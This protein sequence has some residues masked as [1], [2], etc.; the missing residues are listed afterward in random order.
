MLLR[1]GQSDLYYQQKQTRH[2][3]EEQ[4]MQQPD[5]IS[6]NQQAPPTAANA[7][8]TRRRS[9]LALEIGVPGGIL[10]LALLLR[11][12]HLSALT[13]SYDEG[14]YLASLRAMHEGYSLFTPV[15][16]SQP[17]FFLLSLS[18][19]I[20][21]FG[22]TFL[23]ARGGVV[24]FSLIGVLAMY[25]LG[26]R[27][28]GL[29]VGAAAAL[30]L[31]CDYLFLIQSQT[32]EAE[33]PSVALMIV[34]V[35]AA[36]YIGRYPWQAA[37][38]SG[39]ATALATLE[40]LFAGTV[41][42]PIA[43]LFLGHL[44]TYAQTQQGTSASSQPGAWRFKSRLE[45]L[46]R[47][48]VRLRG[49]GRYIRLSLA[50][51]G[52][53]AGAY[54]AGLVLTTTL[55]FLPYLGQLQAVYQQ[56][57]GFHLAAGESFAS[58]LS[59]NLRLVLLNTTATYPLMLLTLLGFIVGL[60]RRRWHV[61]TA[62][63]WTLAA[64]LILLRQQPLF[65]HHLVLLIP[66]LALCAAL[67]LMPAPKTF[68]SDMMALQ[69]RLRRLLPSL[70]AQG[71]RVALV[72]LPLLL[73]VGVLALNLRTNLDHPLGLPAADATRLV[74]VANDLRQF[75]TPQQT[76]I[77][78]DQ[79]IAML[80]DRNVPPALVDTSAVRIETGYLTAAQVIAIAQQSQVGAILFYS[81]RFQQLSGFQTWVEQ[82]FHLIKMYGDEQAL[83]LRASP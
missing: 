57:I 56:A 72:G 52:L 60:V 20:W 70:S 50:R 39:V 23:A 40:K 35:A 7:A 36:A 15:F 12:W 53:L 31:A 5:L 59:Q 25:L 16:S 21:L 24:L 29:W 67:G 54:L 32:I 10:L 63:A 22:P 14:V 66:G 44:I 78:D 11:L 74:Q 68:A 17:P 13:D 3:E 8:D 26:R 37:A 80:A 81:G 1:A 77:T 18:P 27:L 83:Y 4:A 76:V 65:P 62:G 41:I 61:L 64:L 55:V 82:H 58:T 2:G 33:G 79:Y 48:E 19:F 43:L 38:L 34:A 45:A 49:L 73:L 28:G 9:A 71:A 6:Q 75:T 69:A 42:V 46:R 47:R 51:A 30:M